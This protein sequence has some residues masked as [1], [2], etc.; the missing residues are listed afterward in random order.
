LFHKVVQ[1]YWEK[2]KEFVPSANPIKIKPG[3]YGG[4][5]PWPPVKINVPITMN[6]AIISNLMILSKYPR[7]NLFL[8]E[9]PKLV[10]NCYEETKESVPSANPVKQF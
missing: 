10:K 3:G 8:A 1:N 5:V 6:V 4:D 7:K 2:T 9:R